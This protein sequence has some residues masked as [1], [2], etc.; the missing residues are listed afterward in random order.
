MSFTLFTNYTNGV[1]LTMSVTGE[2]LG[3]GSQV[4]IALVILVLVYILIGFEVK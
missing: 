2:I 1:A 4:I 3:E